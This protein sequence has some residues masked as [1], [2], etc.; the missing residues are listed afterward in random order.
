MS[1]EWLIWAITLMWFQCLIIYESRGMRCCCLTPETACANDTC[2]SACTAAARLLRLRL[3]WKNVAA[4]A[5]RITAT[6]RFPWCQIICL[7]TEHSMNLFVLN[8]G[9]LWHP[10]EWVSLQSPQGLI[11]CTVLL[12]NSPNDASHIS[13]FQILK[14]SNIEKKD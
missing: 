12:R 10:R 2:P 8:E 3:R 14:L 7:C 9:R 1:F 5:L 6:W 4:N 11:T 13:S